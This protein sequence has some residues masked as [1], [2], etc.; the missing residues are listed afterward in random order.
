M[1]NDLY[2]K[3]IFET[4]K[5]GYLKEEIK[6]SNFLKDKEIKSTN[7]KKDYSNTQII[8]VP[9]KLENNK[10]LLIEDLPLNFLLSHTIIIGENTPLIEFNATNNNFENNIYIADKKLLNKINNILNINKNN[11]K[12]IKAKELFNQNYYF[13]FKQPKLMINIKDYLFSIKN[14]PFN[15]IHIVKHPQKVEN[16]VPTLKSTHLKIA[17]NLNLPL[18]PLIKNNYIRE[19]TINIYDNKT[20]NNI[21]QPILTSNTK[22]IF[23]IYKPN[24]LKI[25]PDIKNC[26]II[27]FKKDH[28]IKKILKSQ[29]VNF[30][31][32]KIISVI[33]S[34]NKIDFS[35]NHGKYPLPIW[36]SLNTQ[37]Y[38]EIENTNSFKEITGVN[39]TLNIN[40]FE[41][42]YLQSIEGEKVLYKNRYLH[43]NLN[44]TIET[45]T[46]SKT[47]TFNTVQEL[48]LKLILNNSI[49]FPILLQKQH[50]QH[51]KIHSLTKKIN[52]INN[53]IIENSIKYNK[54]PY[55][56]RP[57]TFTEK[58]Y[59]SLY[60][61]L[62]ESEENFTKYPSQTTIINKSIE[63]CNKI[64][65]SQ[66]IFHSNV[67]DLYFIT[68]C[69][70]NLNKILYIFNSDASTKIQENFN[71]YIKEFPNQKQYCEINKEYEQLVEDI[72][73]SYKISK[74]KETYIYYKQKLPYNFNI[75]IPQFESKP[76]YKEYL[77][78]NKKKINA[79]FKY[80]NKIISDSISKIKPKNLPYNPI[81]KIKD[82]KIKLTPQ[83]YTIQAVYHKYNQKINNNYF[84]L[85]VKK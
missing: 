1:D 69:L 84:E 58:Y 66:K 20:M 31:R 9:V 23:K 65:Q 14:M 18:I 71:A 85:L 41:N 82:K 42:L 21:I 74:K 72:I 79:L 78:P 13:N 73:L 49:E 6:I 5:Q 47:I 29:T 53:I 80:N 4:I 57:Q 19:S 39:F 68:L 16:F 83:L 28:I 48:I 50:I 32:E 63:I 40:K 10:I 43:P 81:L 30:N 8:V 38:V 51:N 25:Y 27:D 62:K 36:K 75:N 7:I 24:N 26:Y 46:E 3:L 17:K 34:L 44:Q 70:L 37:K 11:I 12:E 35:T 15:K 67:E 61:S 56:K 22:K 33:K 2:L 54:T 55:Y 45:L 59:L 52:H 64:I 77:K 60:S 76:T